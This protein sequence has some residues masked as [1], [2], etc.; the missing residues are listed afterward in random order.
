MSSAT[1]SVDNSLWDSLAVEVGDEVDQVEV[2]KEE[3]AICTSTLGLVWMRHWDTIAVGV[4]GLLGWS[5]PVILVG[6]EL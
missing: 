3:G 6:A 5:I 2:L 4:D 1:F